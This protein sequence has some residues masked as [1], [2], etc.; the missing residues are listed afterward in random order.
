MPTVDGILKFVLP[1]GVR[2]TCALSSD[3]SYKNEK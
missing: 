1:S 2:I 3:R